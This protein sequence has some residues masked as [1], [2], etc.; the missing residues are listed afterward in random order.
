VA[1]PPLLELVA[2]VAQRLPRF[3][4]ASHRDVPLRRPSPRSERHR[5]QQLLLED[6]HALRV[7]RY[8]D[9]AIGG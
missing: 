8:A 6:V 5:P 2:D 1:S 4:R 9:R 3:A 7:T